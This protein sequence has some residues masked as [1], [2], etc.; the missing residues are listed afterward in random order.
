MGLHTKKSTV[1]KNSVTFPMSSTGLL[2]RCENLAYSHGHC[3]MTE[4]GEG[5]YL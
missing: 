4:G 1:F 5:G 3:A 2:M